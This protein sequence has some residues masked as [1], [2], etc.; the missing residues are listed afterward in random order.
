VIG[1]LAPH[2]GGFARVESYGHEYDVFVM[3]GDGTHVRRLTHDRFSDSWPNPSPNGKEV[4]YVSDTSPNGSTSEL[5]RISSNGRH[6]IRLATNPDGPP[7]W[8]PDGRLIAFVRS[9]N[10]N[11]PTAPDDLWVVSA[12]GGHER[13]VA[14]A[15]ESFAWSHDGGRIAFGCNGGSLCLVDR[16]G[17]PVRRLA[18]ID[19]AFHGVP[20]ETW[21]ADDR[22]LA[23][24]E[25]IGSS[26]NPDYSA[27]LIGVN[28]RGLHRLPGFGEGNVDAL[29]WLPSR[30]RTLLVTTVTDASAYLLRADGRRK[31]RLPFQ[32]DQV[33]V[34]PDGSKL[35][36]V[37]AVYQSDG[38]RYHSAIYR[39]DVESGSIEQLTQRTR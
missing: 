29:T 25:G 19:D 32:G 8:S 21:S 2:T 30:A 27:W 16:A 34:S 18:H 38:L 7:S 35:L 28:G 20:S 17:G 10:K 12:A 5:D 37:R 14:K 13:R 22:E 4:V 26:D 31:R 23:F 6:K 33:A 24:V 1:V 36:F 11:D 39:A 15:V 9:R 3:N